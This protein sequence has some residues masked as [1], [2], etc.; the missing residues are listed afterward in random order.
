MSF[1]HLLF[2]LFIE[3]IVVLFEYVFSL[4]L[5]LVGDSALALIPLSLLVNLLC[6]PLYRRAD[7]LRRR[8]RAREKEMEPV[9]LHIK[10]HFKG[11]E[12]FM[13]TQ[14]YYR[15]CG[16][17]PIHALR[18][19][20]SLLLQIPFF[21]AA[22]IVLSSNPALMGKS[23]GI[24]ADL[25]Q[26][27]ALLI[28][29]GL[30]ANAF[31]IN[32]L[33]ILMTLV[34]IVSVVVYGWK[35]SGRSEKVQMVGLALIF[36]VL[37]Y[38]SASG[39]VLYWILNQLFSLGKN[40]YDAIAAR[41]RPQ[42]CAAVT[43][44]SG[45][46]KP[47]RQVFLLGGLFL[48]V[49]CGALIPSGVICSAVS[50]FVEMAEYIPPL[51]YVGDAFLTSLG[52]FVIWAGVIYYLA[53]RKG[54]HVL[55]AIMWC[56]AGIAAVNYMFFGTELG[57]LLPSLRFVT[58]PSFSAGTIWANL[59]VIIGVAALFLFFWFK[60][61]KAIRPLQS[62]LLLTV[63]AMSTVN[64]IG[65]GRE[66]PRLKQFSQEHLSA[67]KCTIPL[68]RNGKNVVVLMLD[69]AISLFVPYMFQ[70]KP[71][72]KQQFSGFTYYPNALSFG[73]AT[74]TGSPAL[75]GGY[76]YTP[77]EMNRRK[78]EP[79]VDK[80]NEALHVMPRL[81][82][83]QGYT[84]T[85]CDPPYAGYK[86]PPDLSIFD[87]I[88]GVRTFNTTI[89]DRNINL[90]LQAVWKKNFFCYSLM[91]I[92]PLAL[93]EMLYQDSRYSDSP[94]VKR[95]SAHVW[96]S[97]STAE[98]YRHTT[99]DN[100]TVLCDLPVM[101]DVREDGNTFLMMT[102]NLTHEPMLLQEP[103]YV[104]AEKVDNTVYDQTHKERFT[105]DGRVL[106]ISD[107]ETMAYYQT[108][109]AAMLKLGEWFDYLREQ[110]VYDNTRIILVSDHGKVM[111]LY[112]DMKLDFQIGGD[113]FMFNPFLMVKDFGASG[114]E[115]DNRFMTNAD[116]PSLAFDS[117]IEDPV[118]P[119]TG[120]HI[121]S[122]GKNAD[123]LY[124]A[125][126]MP[127]EWNI[128]KNHGNTFKAMQW[129]SVKKEDIFDVRNWRYV[130][131]Y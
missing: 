24:I 27:D 22:Y 3:P 69:K 125:G 95:I 77:L 25:S 46:D 23:F 96:S 82:R 115:T 56:V 63:A 89:S 88:P 131:A 33:P 91:K 113:M 62:V 104:P 111:N 123:I 30:T 85:V 43:A 121:N 49:L 120:E 116:T 78:N 15:I 130:G 119:Y 100:Y 51:Q 9:L 34:N 18:N 73:A 129:L 107:P 5:K 117:L 29:E 4:S 7:A 70:E 99:I 80:H 105:V 90:S 67:P 1:V 8:T 47:D 17:K 13:L 110:G 39:L 54:R 60:A 16:Y 74:N 41:R 108:D 11:D 65:I 53:A 68:S 114:F 42:S 19:S 6:L 102:N 94:E 97:I 44:P 71:E 28:V 14:A 38:N 87:D 76:E 50:E 81:F 92:S 126:V 101:T 66:Q 32:L 61:D 10:A 20:L 57:T 112:Q 37:L 75:F 45:N 40:I 103:E 59:A 127:G 72:L 122:D 93:Q 12:R 84:V 48:A 118:N 83:D 98:G 52:A 106:P 79:L 128:N 64:C 109:M 26:P 36:L 35:E 86:R 55:A 21:M 124:V 58:A 2:Q 31:T